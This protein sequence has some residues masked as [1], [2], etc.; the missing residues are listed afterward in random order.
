MFGIADAA[1]GG[2]AV[3][4]GTA[5]CAVGSPMLRPVLLGLLLVAVVAASV[6]A[7]R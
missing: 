5:G 3:G 7:L 1:G 2:A 4:F 6:D